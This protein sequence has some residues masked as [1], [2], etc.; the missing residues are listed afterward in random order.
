LVGVGEG[1]TLGDTL[2]DGVGAGEGATAVAPL[3]VRP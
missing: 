2:A 1:D 3:A